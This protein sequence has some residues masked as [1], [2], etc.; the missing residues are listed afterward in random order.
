MD[1]WLDS[2][3][4]NSKDTHEAASSALPAELVALMEDKGLDKNMPGAQLAKLP[5]ELMDMVREYFNTDGDPLP[6]HAEEAKEHRVKL[7]KARGAFDKTAEAG[8]QQHSYS[9]C[10]H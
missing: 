8:W 3:F 5:M 6:M 7:M 9:F 10:E 4:G 2:V 1:W